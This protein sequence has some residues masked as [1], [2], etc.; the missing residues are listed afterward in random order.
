MTY[1]DFI[2]R[3]LDL[4]QRIEHKIE[5]V[6]FKWTLCLNT[7]QGDGEK[8]QKSLTNT[9]EVRVLR[10]AEANRELTDLQEEYDASCAN[11]REFLYGCLDVKD[12]DVLDWKYCSGKSIADIAEIRGMTYSGM[13]SRI[14]RAETRARSEF[15]QYFQN[16]VDLQKKSR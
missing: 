7:I 15:S 12:A 11:V 4:M 14:S 13:A 3:P 2:N 10:Y 9:A 6:Q 8:I 1:S 5:D 16:C